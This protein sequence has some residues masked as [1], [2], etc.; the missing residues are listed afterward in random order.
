MPAVSTRLAWEHTH[1]E[2]LAAILFLHQLEQQG[3]PGCIQHVKS[4]SSLGRERELILLPFFYDNSD[5]GRYLN[6]VDL[7]SKVIVNTAYEQFHLERARNYV[8][9]D[10]DF[11]Q[12]NMLHCAWGPR[13]RDMLL[14][15]GVDESR[16]RMTGHPRFDIYHH[17]SLLSTREELA[18]DF[19]LD[20]GKD[21]VLVPYNFNMAYVNERRIASMNERG[22]D[23]GHDLIDATAQAR[24]AFTGMVKT[25]SASCP[26]KEIILRV[27]PAGYEASTIYAGAAEQFPNLHI[28]SSY[29][30]GNWIV[31][32]ALV[33][34]WTSTSGLEA[35]VA[36]VPVVSYEPYPF[37]ERW[38]YDLN[39]II[40]TFKT[41]DDIMNVV[42]Q[43]PNPELEYDIALF[44]QWHAFSDGRNVARQVALGAELG[45]RWDEVYVP[46]DLPGPGAMTRVRESLQRVLPA[47]LRK[48]PKHAEPPAGPLATAAARLDTHELRSFLQ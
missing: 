5:I 8:M 3:V 14:E 27:H 22:Y 17:R 33:I 44:E 4:L 31:Q 30:I 13:F 34:V 29:D 11:A 15:R 36:D 38:D 23:V 47:P 46:A 20:A 35:L 48:A 32:S 6:R 2:M 19:A 39:R 26:D 12:K 24:D 42:A 43:L 16:I 21:W 45:E 9:P 37:S 25:L 28:I 1:R 10:G 40:P 41:V 18:S 7:T